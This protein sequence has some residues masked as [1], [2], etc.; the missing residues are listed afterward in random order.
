MVV[1]LL[2]LLYTMHLTNSLTLK[3]A[4]PNF[5]KRTPPVLEAERQK[6]SLPLA[7]HPIALMWSPHQNRTPWDPKS[8]GLCGVFI[9]KI[10]KVFWAPETH[11]CPAN[12]PFN[13]SASEVC[14]FPIPTI[15]QSHCP[16]SSPRVSRRCFFGLNEGASSNFQLM[17]TRPPIAV[18]WFSVDS[19]GQTVLRKCVSRICEDDVYHMISR[20]STFLS[21]GCNNQPSG[22]L[23]IWQYGK[24]S[25]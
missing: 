12:V 6:Y 23:T 8:I 13:G 25:V 17:V 18:G 11:R 2:L 14:R 9:G 15:K 22:S 16:Y 21:W 1:Q 7:D 19:V 10:R 4:H 24:W 20:C 3:T 5:T